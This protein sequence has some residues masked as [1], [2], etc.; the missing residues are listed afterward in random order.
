MVA[1][2]WPVKNSGGN[3]F[4]SAGELRMVELTLSANT[5]A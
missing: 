3:Y 4:C 5:A 2:G 1:A